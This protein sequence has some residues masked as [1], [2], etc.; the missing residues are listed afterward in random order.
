MVTYRSFM[1]TERTRTWPGLREA[2]QQPSRQQVL[3]EEGAGEVPPPSPLSLALR[4][5]RHAAAARGSGT[6]RQSLGATGVAGAGTAV[7]VA[8]SL[9]SLPQLTGIATWYRYR[10]ATT[11]V[12]QLW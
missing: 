7:K 10:I 11:V 9:V 3:G 6:R 4:Y 1:A 2:F 8:C 12:P 5:R